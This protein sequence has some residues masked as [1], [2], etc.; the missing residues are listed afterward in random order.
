M[1]ILTSSCGASRMLAHHTRCTP[2]LSAKAMCCPCSQGMGDLTR[3][4]LPVQQAA[5]QLALVG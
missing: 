4:L 1:S 2:H 3:G 5:A